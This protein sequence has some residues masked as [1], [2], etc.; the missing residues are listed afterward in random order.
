MMVQEMAVLV[1]FVRALCPAQKID[2]Y[3]PDAWMLVIGDLEFADAE[4]AI[5]KLGRSQPF[6][7]AADIAGE[8][9]KIRAARLASY[10]ETEP[11]V[12]DPDNVQAY[13]EAIR[14]G[15]FKAASNIEA[16]PRPVK[17]LTAKAFHRVPSVWDR[18]APITHRRFA[19]PAGPDP[20]PEPVDPEHAAANAVLAELPNRHHWLSEA[21]V[22]LE[23]EGQ[24]LNKRD[25][26]IRAADLATRTNSTEGA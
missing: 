12:E 8:V 23:R 16:R 3:T 6:I 20:E 14:A 4:A 11:D 1:R 25:V 13:I 7:A 17:A 15:R 19:L 5:K 9:S 24:L 18:S 21:A 2:E 22:L 26:A 10:V